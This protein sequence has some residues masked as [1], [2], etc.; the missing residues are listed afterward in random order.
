M[1]ISNDIKY[2]YATLT[3]A[4]KLIVI[5]VLV[6]I[7]NILL[8]FLFRLSPDFLMQWF[9]LPKRL[10][11]FITQPWSVVTYAF[12]HG[13]FSHIFWN[14]LLLY[15]SGRIFLNLFGGRRFLNVYFL[16]A[17][18]GGL[19]FMLSY[20]LFPA[21]ME[22][23]TSLIG[24]SAAVM[25]I[26]IFICTYMPNQEVRL[27]FLFNIK[28]WYIGV[29]VVLIDLVQIP[30]SNAGGHLAHLGGAL[31]GYIY[32]R[33]LSEG[34]D[35]GSGFEKMVTAVVN[36]FRRKPKG[37][38]K[39]VHKNRKTTASAKKSQAGKD[40]RQQKIDEILDKISKSGYESLTK[41]E[42]DFLFQAGK[43]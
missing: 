32:A 15:F 18:A 7:L 19:I 5:N 43:D 27:F 39:T 36:L 38:L 30:M 24:A 25:A 23:D 26:L 35:I 17:I 12:F 4:E 6:Y 8:V 40:S 21:F 34:R 33:K 20:N 14:M 22:I 11:N 2:K 9:E 3:V 13:S 41:E 31:L 16:G 29:F 28:L 1:G 10:D 37:P 42:K